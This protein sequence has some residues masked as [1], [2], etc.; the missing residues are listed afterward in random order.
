MTVSSHIE[1]SR[2][3]HHLLN[4]TLSGLD[5][6]ILWQELVATSPELG[7]VDTQV[8]AF[9]QTADLSYLDKALGLLPEPPE[10]KLAPL[11]VRSPV[12]QD[13]WEVKSHRLRNVSRAEF[14]CQHCGWEIAV[15]QEHEPNT[16]MR[17]PFE[18]FRCPHC[19]E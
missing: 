11:R 14:R 7:E 3:L 17:L 5:F 6:C 18:N 13:E 1:A 19:D 4:Q 8:E 9:L 12:V 2:L 15:S 16:E 10:E